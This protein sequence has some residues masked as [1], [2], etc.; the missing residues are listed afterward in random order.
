MM[1]MER[2]CGMRLVV[3]MNRVKKEGYGN[4]KYL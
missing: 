2:L 1:M 3:V 4:R